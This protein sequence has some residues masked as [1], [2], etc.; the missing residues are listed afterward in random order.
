M[1]NRA[2]AKGSRSGAGAL[3]FN[4]QYYQHP[5]TQSYVEDTAC[6]GHL[7][8]DLGYSVHDPEFDSLASMC[9]GGLA[10]AAILKLLRRM[11]S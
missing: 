6:F 9:Q 7:L 3:I 4:I 11:K 10:A 1:K 5:R 8:W 2:A